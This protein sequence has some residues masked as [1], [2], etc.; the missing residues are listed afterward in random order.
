MNRPFRKTWKEDKS[1]QEDPQ[2]LEAL[3]WGRALLKMDLVLLP[4]G[5]FYMGGDALK[6]GELIT[7]PAGSQV[8]F[9]DMTTRTYRAIL[10]KEHTAIRF[11]LPTK[12]NPG[13]YFIVSISCEPEV[14]EG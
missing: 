10:A 4:E 12:D 2:L 6:L 11:K 13:D 3:R 8:Y 7:I 5:N 1:K 9:A 14:T